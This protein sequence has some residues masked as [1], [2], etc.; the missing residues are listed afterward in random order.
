MRAAIYCRISQ[1]RSDEGL[2]VARQEKDCRAQAQRRKWTVSE[3]FVD[4]DVSAYT[5]TKRRKKRPAY[6]RMMGAIRAGTVDALLV[7]HPD[8]L[9][10]T[11]RELED[12][13]D[14]IEEHK[15]T[16]A[17]V[18]AG[19][20]D[21][22]TPDGRLMARITGSVARKE[23][24]DKSRR[25]LRKHLELAENGKVGGGGR[26]P[27]GY[28]QDRRTI[29]ESEAVEIRKAADRLLAGESVRSITRSWREGGV[30]S[31]TG[32]PWSPT[33]VTR[34]LRSARI[35]GQREHRGV[36][37]ADAEWP[38]IITAETTSKIRTILDSPDRRAGQRAARDYLLSG[39]VRCE[40]CGSKLTARPVVRKG[41][42]YRRYAC[43]ADRGGCNRVGIGAEPLEALV[44]EATM[45]RLDT[46][47]LARAVRGKRAKAPDSSAVS[48]LAKL[49]AR[50]AELA[51]MWASGD[52]QRAE[53]NVARSRLQVNIDAARKA[54]A[55]TI[56]TEA[57]SAW[58]GEGKVLRSAWV[59]M[60]LDQRRA[61]LAS[62]IDSVTIAVTTRANNKFDPERVD[63]IWLV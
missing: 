46:P 20:Y 62:V 35:S 26:R 15:V 33:T 10:R 24:E 6:E 48:D 52:L 2:G 45:L 16:V 7:W 30:P 38:A 11:P 13:I 56:R 22:A 34:L 4:N 59:D 63:V 3:V 1:D 55:A 28:E 51:E 37:T 44:V 25:L 18:A 29:R 31:V 50:Q 8:R 57:S 19:D 14:L 21:L 40:A 61:V 58:V 60:S 39:F 27:F 42:R 47:A 17:S 49:E 43:A 36:I 32:A 5:T 53:W 54:A 12:F 23:S 9:H 41:H